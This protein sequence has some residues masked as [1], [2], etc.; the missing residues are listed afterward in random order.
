MQPVPGEK[1]DRNYEILIYLA[2][3]FKK[4][5]LILLAPESH[6]AFPKLR[7]TVTQGWKWGA[8]SS[9]ASAPLPFLMMWSFVW[10]LRD[11]GV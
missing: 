1:E 10:V 9:R 4:T 3:G 6:E 2:A 7:E 11:R 8:G 5:R